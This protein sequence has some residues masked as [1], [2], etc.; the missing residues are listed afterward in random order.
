MIEPCTPAGKNVLSSALV[1]GTYL[2]RLT[3]KE[4][5]PLLRRTEVVLLPLGA[6]LKEHGLHLPLNTDW[7]LAEGLAARV[8]EAVPV[9][10]VPTL[11]YGY[12]PAFIE[13]PGSVTVRLET[14]RDLVVDVCRSLAP[15][16]PKKFYVLNTGISTL[17]ALAP[18]KVQLAGEGL[19]MEYTDLSVDL[20][21]VER[22][23]RRQEA[24]SHADEI[25][26]SMMLYLA[27]EMVNL[28]A[29]VRD[30]HPDKGPGGLTRDPDAAS[31]VYSPTGAWGDPTLATREKGRILV[32]TLVERLVAAVERLRSEG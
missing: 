21:D 22:Q 23:V 24:G 19:R 15:F 7:R 6:R 26:T 28:P 32:E 13:Y 14:C 9:V 17:K 8:V 20:A 31:G 3:W 1:K 18:A 11:Q 12:Y 2:E 29:A 4:A 25:E 5:E 10:A 30:I 27:P 16:G